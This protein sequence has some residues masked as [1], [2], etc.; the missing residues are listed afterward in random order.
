[1]IDSIPVTVIPVPNTG[2]GP[3]G[4]GSST[5]DGVLGQQEMVTGSV[6]VQYSH[7]LSFPFSPHL[8]EMADVPLYPVGDDFLYGMAPY[9]LVGTGAAQDTQTPDPFSLASLVGGDLGAPPIDTGN[10]NLLGRC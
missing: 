4:L 7:A 8:I 2:A 10:S 9:P 6:L 3:K 5:D 1:M